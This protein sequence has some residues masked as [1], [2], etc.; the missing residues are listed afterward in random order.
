[1]TDPEDG[2]ERCYREHTVDIPT[3]PLNEI[4]EALSNILCSVVGNM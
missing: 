3:E 1:M 4:D 2:V